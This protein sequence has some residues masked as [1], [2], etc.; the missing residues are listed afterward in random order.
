[1]HPGR[2]LGIVL[3]ITVIFFLINMNPG[4]FGLTQNNVESEDAW[5]PDNELSETIDDLKNNY[6]S[7]VVYCQ[8]LVK[9]KNDNVL[10]KEALNDILEVEKQIANNSKVKKVL[11]PQ[12]GNITSISSMI[13]YMNLTMQGIPFE[14]ITDENITE[15]IRDLRTSDIQTQLLN[16]KNFAEGNIPGIPKE[17]SKEAET[18]L[19]I[20]TRLCIAQP[21][22]S[23]LLRTKSS[24]I[25][26]WILVWTGILE[27]K[28]TAITISI[29]YAVNFG[30]KRPEAEF[31]GFYFAGQAQSE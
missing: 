29:R 23:R 21:L 28:G 2:T 30:G 19:N 9:G 24:V 16:L 4:M 6:G 26:I 11:Y 1:M 8:I 7:N 27:A 5:F 15:V 13:A 22:S 17:V 3:I 20:G 18:A 14:E 10:T 31:V 25:I 12:P